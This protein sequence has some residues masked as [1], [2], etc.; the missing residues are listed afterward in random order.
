MLDYRVQ[1]KEKRRGRPL[2]LFLSG[3]TFFFSQYLRNVQCCMQKNNLFKLQTLIEALHLEPKWLQNDNNDDYERENVL[4]GGK[5]WPGEFL[6]SH[7][8]QSVEY[9][10]SW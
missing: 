6:R 4:Q 3:S 7:P 1:G 5:K 8:Q 2:F 10:T 9:R